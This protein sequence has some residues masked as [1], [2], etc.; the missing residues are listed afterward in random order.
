MDEP[1][2]DEL[3]DTKDFLAMVRAI[4][5]TQ[6][7]QLLGKLIAFFLRRAVAAGVARVERFDLKAVEG[8]ATCRAVE[9]LEI[10]TFKTIALRRGL[11]TQEELDETERELTA[12]AP[13]DE[14]LAGEVGSRLTLMRQLEQRLLASR[15]EAE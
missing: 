2:K 4:E 1:P 7:E 9:L 5:L 11:V 6:E 8:L 3:H 13:V 14:L 10:L 15:G 12:S